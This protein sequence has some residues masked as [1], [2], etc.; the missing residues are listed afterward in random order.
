MPEAKEGSEGGKQTRAT[1]H[2]LLAAA[3]EHDSVVNIYQERLQSL[4]YE[5]ADLSR[6]IGMDARVELKPSRQRFELSSGY[7]VAL[8][9]IPAEIPQEVFN[10]LDELFAAAR[11]QDVRGAAR[12]FLLALIDSEA[13]RTKGRVELREPGGIRI[14]FGAQYPEYAVGLT[15]ERLQIALDVWARRGGPRKN[16]TIPEKWVALADLMNVLDLG[17]IKPS[18]LEQQWLTCGYK[19]ARSQQKNSQVPELNS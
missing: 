9:P 8:R 10:K 15:D 5:L 11:D 2:E 1:S 14:L 12:M 6:A 7:Y 13:K 18:S 17:P 4:F 16:K 19:R 3:Y